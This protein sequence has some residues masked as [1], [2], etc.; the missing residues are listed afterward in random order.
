MVLDVAAYS[1]DNL[2]VAAARTFLST[3][4]FTGSPVGRVRFTNAD[5]GN[6]RGIDIRLDRRIGNLFNGTISYSYQDSKSTGSDPLSNQTAGVE[7]LE[8]IGGAIGPP[9]Q[10]ILPTNYSRPHTLAGAVSLTFPPDW[11]R[12]TVPGAVLGNLGLFAVFRYTS[13]TPYTT[14]PAAEGN[15]NWFASSGGCAQGGG[16]INGARLPAYRQFDLRITKQFG[17]GGLGLTTYLDARNLF[18][19]ANILEVFSVTRHISNPADQ[20]DRWAN[21]SS[22]YA[23]EAKASGVYADD[24]SLDL[25]F[26]GSVA[27]GC[28]LWTSGAGRPAAPNCVYLIRAEER[29]GNGDHIFSVSEQ[30]RASNAY[31]AAVGRNQSF[32][33]RGRHNLTGD[34]RRL[35][36]GVEVS[37]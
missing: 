23:T 24:G 36:L 18:N 35:R 6:T 37:F 8:E 4:P 26:G 11:R 22:H 1:K 28:G 29:Y 20:Q 12:G 15:E 32:F 3:D 19:F 5:Y 14:C 27:A 33:A 16:A 30:R 17:L 34:P 10:A 9:P 31:Y 13:G 25:R 21:D 2:A 7:A